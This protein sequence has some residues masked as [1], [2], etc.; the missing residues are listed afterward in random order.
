ML[1][2]TLSLF[3]IVF[4]GN[5]LASAR[6]V[7]IQG[8][9]QIYIAVRVIELYSLLNTFKCSHDLSLD[10]SIKMTFILVVFNWITHSLRWTGRCLGLS[11]TNLCGNCRQPPLHFYKFSDRCCYYT[12]TKHHSSNKKGTSSVAFPWANLSLFFHSI[13]TMM[14]CWAFFKY[15]KV[16]S[17]M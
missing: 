1:P 14:A 3:V 7:W 12:L 5:V 16:R 10:L 9:P 11:A 6:Y 4:V 17:I 8:I 15:P 2:S 13:G